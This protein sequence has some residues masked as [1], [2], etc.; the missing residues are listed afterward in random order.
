[1]QSAIVSAEPVIEKSIN[2]NFEENNNEF[3]KQ[4]SIK[5]YPNPNNGIFTIKTEG[6]D[7]D[8][9]IV[10]YN[11]HGAIVYQDNINAEKSIHISNI[12]RG[13]YFVKTTNSSKPLTQ[14][15]IIR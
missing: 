9:R 12:Q 8:A 3:Q 2:G 6:F 4:Q 5:V 7:H 1:V 15:I 13:L 11:F 14:K 10:I